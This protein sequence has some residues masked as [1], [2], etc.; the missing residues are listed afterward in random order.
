MPFALGVI[1]GILICTFIFVVIVATDARRFVDQAKN[2]VREAAKNID[3]KL[4]GGVLPLQRGF[5]EIPAD[6]DELA[7]Q[8]IIEENRSK[9]KDTHI[10]EL[11]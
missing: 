5:V 6:D 10:S 4:G 7:R 3:E 2:T 8:E 1:V 11:Q 9:G